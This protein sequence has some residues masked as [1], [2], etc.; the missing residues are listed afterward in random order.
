M[1]NLGKDGVVGVEKQR[2]LAPFDRILFT[3]YDCGE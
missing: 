3:T 1:Q 2:K